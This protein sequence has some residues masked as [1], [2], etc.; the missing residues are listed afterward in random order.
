MGAGGSRGVP[1]GYDDHGEVNGCAGGTSCFEPVEERTATHWSYVG[2]GRGDFEPRRM[3]SFVGHGA[4]SFQRETVVVPQGW[5]MKPWCCAVLALAALALSTR[6]FTEVGSRRS[7]AATSAQQVEYAPARQAIQQPH[8]APTPEP[9][10]RPR[11]LCAAPPLLTGG[12]A[13]GSKR[14]HTNGPAALIGAAILEATWGVADRDSNGFLDG[15][16]L[17]ICE[18]EKCISTR[19]IWVL[20]ATA[21]GAH[22]HLSRAGFMAALVRAGLLASPGAPSLLEAVAAS[23]AEA[24]WI[25]ASNAEDEH[26]L[27]AKLA[28]LLMAARPAGLQALLTSR[29]QEL[30]TEADVNKDGRLDHAE[31]RAGLADAGLALFV[32]DASARTVMGAVAGEVLWNAAGLEPDGHLNRTDLDALKRKHALAHGLHLPQGAAEGK[33]LL[34]KD[35]V[36]MVAKDDLGTKLVRMLSGKAAVPSAAPNDTWAWALLSPVHSWSTPKKTWCCENTGLGCSSAYDCKDMPPNW[37]E[38]WSAAR[39]FWCCLHGAVGCEKL[40]QAPT[41]SPAI[42]STSNVPV[43]ARLDA[44]ALGLPYDCS[45][46]FSAWMSAWSQNKQDFCCKFAGRG[47]AVEPQFNCNAGLSRWEQGWTRAKKDWCCQHDGQGCST[48]TTPKAYN[49]VVAYHNWKHAW[50][51][52]KKR[53][54]CEQFGRAC[55]HSE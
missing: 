45:V 2:R 31:F 19:G 5:R 42:P 16:E 32:A 49:C 17:D 9:I 36:T 11:F 38:V 28:T 33:G 24:A 53:F 48:T 13:G 55:P 10:V 50:S 7:A 22:V 12:G 51:E 30:M 54:C 21:H 29:E 35:F 1:R 34:R 41:V 25:A 20:R 40:R 8:A 15:R 47:C 6:L 14:K 44:T 18:M 39:Q 23:A 27:L 37:R 3:Y 4:G 46:G 43:T 26:L 52:E